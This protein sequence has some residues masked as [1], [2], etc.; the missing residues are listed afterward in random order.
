MHLPIVNYFIGYRISSDIAYY[1]N[2]FILN[3]A[4]TQANLKYLGI[5]L[6]GRPRPYL[7]IQTWLEAT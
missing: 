4:Y 3:I 6:L 2:L 7:L 1:N 5:P